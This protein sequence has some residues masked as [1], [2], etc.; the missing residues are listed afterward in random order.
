MVVGKTGCGKSSLANQIIC[1]DYFKVM[2]STSS[3]T[4]EMTSTNEMVQYKGS[5]YDITM[6][7]TVGFF[8]TTGKY[9]N[10]DIVEEIR[11]KLKYMA[12]DG[13]NL[14]LFIVRVGRFTAE[15]KH[16]FSIILKQFRGYV[17]NISALVI[18]HCEGKSQ[19]ARKQIEKD[20]RESDETKWIA[21]MMTKGIYT[22]GFPDV[23]TLDNDEMET[24]RRKAKMDVEKLHKLI[25]ECD[26]YYLSREI[27][28]GGT[29]YQLKQ[30]IFGSWFK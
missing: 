18:T 15:E 12:P 29:W 3:V 16:S 24:R 17:T 19:F 22:V 6:I 11:E 14:V 8:D 23:S 4:R 27:L 5:S 20:F 2:Q 28:A 25:S 7:D 1:K 26:E 13:I 9:D 10:K 21:D 30:L